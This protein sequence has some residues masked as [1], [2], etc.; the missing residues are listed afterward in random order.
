MR[1][2]MV[3]PKIMCQKHLC[4]EHVE[5]HMFIGT[6]KKGVRIDG[7]LKNNCCEPKSIFQRHIDI[8]EEMIARGYNHQSPLELEDCNVISNLSEI[9]KNWMID[10]SLAMNDLLS[11]CP[12]CKK[13]AQSLI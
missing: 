1:M 11:R 4:G 8:S 9:Q 12:E 2:W 13:R 7:F 10:S 5:L 6:L 3:D